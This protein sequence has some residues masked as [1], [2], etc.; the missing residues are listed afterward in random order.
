[1]TRTAEWRFSS[2]K[3]RWASHQTG[4]IHAGIYYRA[5]SLKAQLCTTAA[6]EL[7]AFCGSVASRTSASES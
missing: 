1:M 4:V 6:R 3:R 5:G 2:A 7:Y